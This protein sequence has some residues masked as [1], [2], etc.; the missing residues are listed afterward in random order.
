MRLDLYCMTYKICRINFQSKQ[1]EVKQV[2][3]IIALGAL[4]FF[5]AGNALAADVITFPAKMGDV[6]FNHKKHQEVLKN[7]K[8]CHTKKPGKIEGFG[9]DVAHKLC[10][11]CHKT[12]SNGKGPVSCKACH[13]KK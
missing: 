7:C 6:Q 13:K 5:C 1:K 10:I 8:D 3:K 4:I 2:K 9:K 11:D 12:K